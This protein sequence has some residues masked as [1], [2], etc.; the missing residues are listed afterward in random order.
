[1]TES[2]EVLVTMT[3]ASPTTWATSARI[4]RLIAWFSVAASRDSVGVHVQ[5][6]HLPTGL[7]GHLRDRWS[8]VT[9]SPA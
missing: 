4:E 5:D 1:M 7:S 3:A 6:G 9:R 8:R 2:A